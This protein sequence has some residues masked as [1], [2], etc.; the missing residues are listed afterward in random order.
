LGRACL[1]QELHTIADD[2]KSPFPKGGFRGIFNGM[3]SP[4]APL[5][6][7]GNL[8]KQEYFVGTRELDKK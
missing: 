3:K 2:V 4:L 8:K 1:I 5:Y 7:G 6:K